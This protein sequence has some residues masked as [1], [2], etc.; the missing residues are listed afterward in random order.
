[1]ARQGYRIHLNNYGV[2]LMRRDAQDATPA[3]YLWLD[4]R[5]KNFARRLAEAQEAGAVYRMT[6]PDGERDEARLVFER[7]LAGGGR[8]R[9]YKMFRID[10]RFAENVA[11]RRVS[12]GASPQTR[13]AV[14]DV[15]RLLQ[16]GY[17][18]RDL[19][20]ADA[21]HLLLERTR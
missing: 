14:A 11:E 7:P 3:E 4:A 5:G 1:L 6:S 2:V 21:A 16:E 13:A 17:V 20:W 12:V 10:L 19:F 8:R 9:D 18:V 15:G